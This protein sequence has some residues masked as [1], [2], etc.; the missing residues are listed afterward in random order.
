[1]KYISDRYCPLCKLQNINDKTSS[2]Y[3]VNLCLFCQNLKLNKQSKTSIL[4]CIIVVSLFYFLITTQ[5]YF[6][7]IYLNKN[8]QLYFKIFLFF[9]LV[10]SITYYIRDKISFRSEIRNNILLNVGKF[11][12]NTHS[13]NIST[14]ICN[15]C[16]DFIC[17][18]ETVH[19]QS[20]LCNHCIEQHKT[21]NHPILQVIL[22]ILIFSIISWRFYLVFR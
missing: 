2:I 15:N 3:D 10:S 6:F 20:M 13:N 7:D 8:Q 5:M 17:N 22:I 18:I 9:I 4:I 16:N 14:Q 19:N 21:I 12:C 11:S 1:M